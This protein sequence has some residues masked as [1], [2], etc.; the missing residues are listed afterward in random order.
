MKY[1][2]LLLTWIPFASV[3]S[4]SEFI[5]DWMLLGSFAIPDSGSRIDADFIDVLES[6]RGGAMVKGK[7][8]MIFHSPENSVDFLS[9]ILKYKPS[10]RCEAYACVYVWSR[11]DQS[12]TLFAGSDDDL[13][14]WCNGLK[15]HSVESVRVLTVDQDTITVPLQTG[16]NT[17]LFKVVNNYG[18]WG[19]SARFID[20]VGISVQPINPHLPTKQLTP[21][22]VHLYDSVPSTTFAL[23]SDDNPYFRLEIPWIN[24]GESWAENV[25]Y[26]VT[27]GKGVLTDSKIAS[28]WGGEL[29]TVSGE[30]PLGSYLSYVGRNLSFVVTTAHR[31]EARRDTLVIS[32]DVLQKFFSEW[33]FDG[34]T[35]TTAHD[36]LIL[37]RTFLVP[38]ELSG[39]QL[40]VAAN[41]GQYW[42]TVTA[43]GDTLA[44]RFSGDSGDLE[45]AS[46]AEAGT[47]FVMEAIVVLDSTVKASQTWRMSFRPRYA[48][49]E[50]YLDDV[51][52][53]KEI[54][55]VDLGEQTALNREVILALKSGSLT[56]IPRILR[57]INDRIA[58]LAPR[59]TEQTIHMVGNAHIDM[60]W[61]WRVPETIL[62]V[63]RTFTT[64]LDNLRR[65]P[66]FRFAHGQ[67]HSYWWMER[68]EPRPFEEIRRYVQE[69]RWEII[70]GTWVESDV[71]I[72]SGESLVRQYFYGKRYF[73]NRFGVDVKL[74]WMPDSF[75]HPATLPQVLRKVGIETYV[76]FRPWPEQR[77]FFWEGPD[78][79]RVL[80]HRPPAWYGTWTGIPK[81]MWRIAVETDTTFG[82]DQS[83]RY[84]GIGDHGGGPS[85]REIEDILHL[86]RLD[87]Y[88]NVRMSTAAEYYENV[89]E[90]RTDFEVDRGEQ[91]F[92]FRGCYTSQAQHKRNNRRAESLLSAVETFSTVAMLHGIRYP[93]ENLERLW[94][95]LLFNQFHDLLAGSGIHPIYLDAQKEYDE[96]FATGSSLLDFRFSV[97]SAQVMTKS[98]QKDSTPIILYN[99]L[100]WGRT[101]PVHLRLPYS[102]ANGVPKILDGRG[103][104]ITS[105][106]IDSNE[107]STEVV[108]LP[109]EIPSVGYS[110][111]WVVLESPRQ[112]AV[113]RQPRAP[114]LENEFLRVSVDPETGCI[115]RLY[116]KRANRDVLLPAGQGNQVQIFSEGAGQNAWDIGTLTDTTLL[117]HADSVTIVEQGPVRSTIRS[118]YMYRGNWIELDVSLYAGLPRVDVTVR[119]N[120]NLKSK[121]VKIA[122][123]LNLKN[124]RATYEVQFG[125]VERPTNGEEVP[126]LRWIDV[127]DDSYGITMVNDSKYGFDVK[128]STMRMTAW[129][130]PTDPDSIADLGHHEFRFALF[131]HLETW[132]RVNAVRRGAEFNTPTIAVI[133]S[134]HN[135]TLPPSFS[136]FSVGPENVVVTALKK[137]DDSEHVVVRFYDAFGARTVVRL[138]WFRN[139]QAVEE[140]DLMEWSSTPMKLKGR[141]LEVDLAPHEIKTLRLRF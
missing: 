52:F 76:F 110:T 50:K 102:L 8:W 129:R 40:T 67:A 75:G 117:M 47:R 104:V 5:K 115:A 113:D 53:S 58:E 2:V 137:A 24:E 87:A 127:S 17:L 4:Q 28:I 44:R 82:L 98:K 38:A 49:I 56:A 74:G 64:A 118:R 3:F 121:L 1:L 61:L 138:A 139:V 135:G 93:Q 70:G 123:P 134:Q 21:E 7:M 71:N 14:V 16:W 31:G 33:K 54:Y 11:S 105:Q 10:S 90:T 26:A 77:M 27:V 9:P 60:A 80:A 94:Y 95:S 22:K 43:N 65:Y 81:E 111:I 63:K 83:I 125:S 141:I 130:T 48:L 59:A 92:V 62:V 122:F 39:L 124:P 51:K 36:T 55:G 79:S 23:G 133:S 57:P 84:F 19:L 25:S 12:R 20:T 119:A 103:R 128:G 140:I 109:P 68:F 18:G 41:I 46:P 120:W 34:W 107:E 106:V 112:P 89:R 73:K 66:D 85:R 42:G 15:I 126:G 86:D 88:P 72:P 132:Q 13:V 29:L 6:P 45:L 32:S 78:G 99:P 108:F 30:I 136:F 114:V 131:P 97:I 91:N 101:D 37:R 96:I 69:G 116:D 35:E 100:N